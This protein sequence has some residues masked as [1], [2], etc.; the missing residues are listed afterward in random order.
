MRQTNRRRGRPPKNSWFN[1][2]AAE[3]RLA[4]LSHV[5]ETLLA[6]RDLLLG[7]LGRVPTAPPALTVS[8]AL[9]ATAPTSSV[10]QSGRRG[11]SVGP[12]LLDL[13]EGIMRKDRPGRR[14]T[15]GELH[16]KLLSI[17]PRRVSAANA[18]A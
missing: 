3:S 7:I 15:V 12:S 13:I 8:P 14:W 1:A 4:E 16:E 9:R 6:E 5:L 18:S 17:A 10:P 2:G 11:L